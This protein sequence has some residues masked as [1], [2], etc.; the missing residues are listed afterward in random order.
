[1]DQDLFAQVAHGYRGDNSANLSQGLLESQVGLLVLAQLALQRT[2]VLDAV[3]EDHGLVRQLLVD[4]G[5][6]IV[7]VLALVLDLVG[8][9]VEMVAQVVELFFGKRSCRL[10]IAAVQLLGCEPVADPLGAL[11]VGAS[12]AWGGWIVGIAKG[13]GWRVAQA[14]L[15]QLSGRRHG[16]RVGVD[17]E[18]ALVLEKVNA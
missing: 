14:V 2:D 10:L 3:L 17:D 15:L 16:E 11:F 5:R 13:A 6:E 7:N 12:A 1:M 8:L 4:F 9:L 18:A